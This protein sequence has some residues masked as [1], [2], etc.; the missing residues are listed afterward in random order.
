MNSLRVRWPN[1]LIKVAPRLQSRW[2]RVQRDEWGALP[3][4]PPS[5]R[6]ISRH[7]SCGGAS[8]RYSQTHIR[9][10]K[11]VAGAN[12]GQARRAAHA[13]RRGTHAFGGIFGSIIDSDL[14]RARAGSVSARPAVR[15]LPAAASCSLPGRAAACGA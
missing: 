10:E 11:V 12:E 4:V 15:R 7:A 2:N 14:W 5:A 8:R 6:L 1:K 9:G 3:P 13:R